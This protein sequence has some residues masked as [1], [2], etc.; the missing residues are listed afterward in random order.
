[1]ICRN[2]IEDDTLEL[3]LLKRLPKAEASQIDW[4]LLSCETCREAAGR[5]KLFV[6][7]LRKMRADDLRPRRSD[8]PLNHRLSART[9]IKTKPS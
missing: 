4:H 1:M 6:E 7:E 9:G 2:Q 3:F 8:Y 5:A